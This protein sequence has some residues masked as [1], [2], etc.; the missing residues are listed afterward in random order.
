[1]TLTWEQACGRAYAIEVSTDGTTWN[2]V[3]RTTAGRGGADDIHFA[4]VE[5]RFARFRGE[6]RAT[7][8]GFSLWEFELYGPEAK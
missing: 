7:E 3:W 6:Q 4:P 2:E 1:M 8:F 5:A